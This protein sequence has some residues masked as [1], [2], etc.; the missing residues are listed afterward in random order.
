MA[1]PVSRSGTSTKPVCAAAEES[2]SLASA[3][4]CQLSPSGGQTGAGLA[5]VQHINT[6]RDP[7]WA[8]ATLLC[9]HEEGIGEQ[10]VFWRG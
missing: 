3:P 1:G 7:R 5:P 8:E 2:A 4:G 9:G 10:E 6:P